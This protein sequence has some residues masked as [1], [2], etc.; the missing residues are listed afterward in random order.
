MD[1]PELSMVLSQ[2]QLGTQLG[3]AIMGKSMEMAETAG[4]E[5]VKMMEQ[6]VYPNLGQ[7]IDISV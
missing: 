7:N 4:D 5:L 2:Q 1:I 3:F 6:S